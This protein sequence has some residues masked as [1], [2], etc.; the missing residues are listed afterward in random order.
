MAA[1]SWRSP[2]TISSQTRTGGSVSWT[3]PSNAGASDN[4]YATAGL[5]TNGTHWLWCTNFGFDTAEVPSGATITG[6]E[7]R[8]ERKASYG[9]A[10]EGTLTRTYYKA[11]KGGAEAGTQKTEDGDLPTTDTVSSSQGGAADV[12][13]TTF[14]DSDARASDTGVAIAHFDDNHASATLSA[15]NVEIRWHYTVAATRRRG[16][17]VSG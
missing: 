15:D 7:V 3:N 8:W 10:T 4:S 9:L 17:A 6:L 1:S 11:I 13:G 14:T 5:A 2:G 16:S 12:W